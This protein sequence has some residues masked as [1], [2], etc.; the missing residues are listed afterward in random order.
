MTQHKPS[1]RV[2][3]RFFFLLLALI[4]GSVPGASPWEMENTKIWQA[5]NSN[6]TVARFL[7]SLPVSYRSD[8]VYLI[9]LDPMRAPRIECGINPFIHLLRK[10]GVK[11][12]IITLVFCRQRRAAER[13]LQKRN[14]LSDYNIIVDND[15]G[16]LNSFV[17]NRD[18]AGVLFAAKFL[19]KTGELLA[20]YPIGIIDSATVAWFVRDNSRPTSP[21]PASRRL[22]RI[23][24]K[25]DRFP[26][27]CD[28]KLRLVSDEEHPLSTALWM[29]INPSG[30]RLAFSD[31]LTGFIYIFDL[32]SGRLN[33][34]LFPDSTEERKF[35]PGM[36]EHV[37][38]FMKQGDMALYLGHAFLDDTTL[39]ISA[40]LPRVAPIIWQGDS[41]YAFYNTPCFIKK[42]VFD[43]KLLNC[44]C[45]HP[46]PDTIPLGFSHPSPSF[47]FQAGV[48]FLPYTRGWPKGSYTLTE[49]VPLEDNPFADE[50]YQRHLYLF[51][52]YRP[53]GEFMNLWGKLS[54]R[55]Q[56]LRLGYFRTVPP[57][58]RFR[59]QRYYL[60][61]G[62]SGKIYIYN[63]DAVLID[64]IRLFD[65]PPLVFPG[66]D[67]AKNPELYLSEALKINFRA[68][69]KDF[70]V[71]PDYCY[72]LLL[73]DENRPI[74]YQV[75]LK[76]QTVRRYALPLRYQGK[77]VKYYLLRE[78]RSGISAVAL[79]ESPAETWYC[80]FRLP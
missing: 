47:L 48:V 37:Y 63:Q 56:Q 24:L 7:R 21:E 74:V 1:W 67:R 14:F 19:V 18:G 28:R 69:I 75:K 49:R 46:L 42:R 62:R 5:Q 20:S 30:N 22:P 2:R 44:Y 64:S 6:K 65:D 79:L 52:A 13:Y 23:R 50:F 11:S 3:G 12:D 34:L 51:A 80:E 58:A 27:R 68:E 33:S 9:L 73:W 31:K 43:N 54:E 55:A 53:S 10:S 78:T 77:E 60:S 66:V 32:N 72:A 41:D 71:T 8:T 45:I 35:S 59:D 61:D 26:L 57:L 16:F 15:Q 70:L 25:T 29:S 36:P 4:I 40:S 76:D 17:F 38:R 39:L